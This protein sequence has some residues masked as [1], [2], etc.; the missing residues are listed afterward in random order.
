MAQPRESIALV[1]TG[2]D[3]PSKN[4]P[5]LGPSRPT[6]KAVGAPTIP[7]K[8]SPYLHQKQNPTGGSNRGDSRHSDWIKGMAEAA[9]GPDRPRG[10]KAGRREEIETAIGA[11]RPKSLAQLHQKQNSS[12]SHQGDR[13]EANFIKALVEAATEPNPNRPNPKYK[14]GPPKHLGT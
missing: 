8:P 3:R 7:R 1:I 12:G 4:H 14:P 2:G 10:S 5:I 6:R 9:S 11:G 13:R